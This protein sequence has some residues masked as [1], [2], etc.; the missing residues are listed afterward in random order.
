M[1]SSLLP[2]IG[3]DIEGEATNDNSGWSVSL[4]ADGS[5]VAIGATY[6]DGNGTDSGHV[7]IYKNVDNQWTQLGNDINGE[8]AN[9]EFGYS[10]SLSDEG[11]VVAVGAHQNLTGSGYVSIYK[12]VNGTWTKVGSNIEGENNGDNAGRSV[13]LSS[14][15]SIVAIGAILHEA[16]GSATGNVRVYKNINDT[17]IQIGRDI[18]GEDANSFS[19]RS[20][21]LSSDGS[22]VAIGADRHDGNGTDSGHVRIYKNVDNNW[23]QVGHDIDGENALDRSGWSVSLSADGSIVAIGASHNDGNGTDSGHVRIYKNIDNNW[24]QVGHDINGEASDNYSGVSVSLSSDGSL[25]AIGAFKNDGNG[26][27]SGHVRIYKNVDNNWI[28]VGHD[29]DGEATQDTFGISVSLSSDGSFVAV[30]GPRNDGNGIDSGHT[31]VYRI[32]LDTT[33]P[34]APISLTTTEAITRDTTPTITG[35]AESGS[36]VTLYK[37]SISDNKTI[38]Y[39]VSVE[40]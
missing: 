7:R 34:S 5:I 40:Q 24:I 14:D 2:Q 16:S 28:Q 31:R 19:G 38:T 13:S 36:I 8:A 1:T 32:D 30:G 25:V 29:I 35:I 10:V 27:D 3:K 12:N 6:N 23:I 37:G 9:D 17:W 26:T 22:I 4:S 33:A 20:V 18:D 15:G 11:N 39:K 21:S